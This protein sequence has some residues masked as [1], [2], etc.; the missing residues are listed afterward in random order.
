MLSP[1][2]GCSLRKYHTGHSELEALSDYLLC[3][4]VQVLEPEFV[5]QGLFSKAGG[6]MGCANPPGNQQTRQAQSD[7][8]PGL[9]E[10]RGGAAERGS[11][12][13]TPSLPRQ[14]SEAGPLVFRFCIPRCRE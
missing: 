12:S 13:L 14:Q 9:A 6:G 7:L 1:Y 11:V 4:T 8:E 5:E 2:I 10:A 3:Y